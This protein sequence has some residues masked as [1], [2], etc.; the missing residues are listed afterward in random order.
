MT[1]FVY[2]MVNGEEWED[3][4]ILLTDFEAIEASIAHPVLE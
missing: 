2:L 3:M 1:D 4:I